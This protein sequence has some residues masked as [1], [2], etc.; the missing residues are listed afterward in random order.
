[1][2]HFGRSKLVALSKSADLGT[3]TTHTAEPP[4]PPMPV[5]PPILQPPPLPARVC[6]CHCWTTRAAT[7]QP[8]HPRCRPPAHPRCRPP[9]PTRRYHVEATH[10]HVDVVT[11]QRRVDATRRRVDKAVYRFPPADVAWMLPI[12]VRGGLPHHPPTV[13]AHKTPISCT[14]ISS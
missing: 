6:C 4:A 9:L 13:G 10:R 12:G 2:A 1:M 11:H 5:L 14:N 3:R 7:L 8:T